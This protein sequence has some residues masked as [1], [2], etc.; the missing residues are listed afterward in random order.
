MTHILKRLEIIKSSIA[1]EELEIVEQ[2]IVKLQ[3]LNIDEE[4]RLI[5]QNLQDGAYATAENLIQ[6]YLAKFSGIVIYVDAEVQKLKLEL[7]SLESKLQNLIEQKTK[8]LSN[9]EDFNIQYNLRLG[10]LI[11]NILALKK[12]IFYKRTIKQRLQKEKYKENL[13]TFDETKETI[14]ELKNSISELEEALENIDE[15]NEEYEKL[16]KA[17]K[18]LQEELKK[19]EIELENQE[20]ELEKAKEFIEDETI[21]EEYEESK[22]NFDEYENEYNQIREN[23][24][25]VAQLSK[26]DEAELKRLYRKAARLCHPDLLP[27][28]LKAK[29]T[30]IMQQLS[31]AN[32]KK[33]LKRVKEILS[34]LENGTIF[35][36]KDY[37]IEDKIKLQEKIKEYQQKIKDT[38]D[39]IARIMADETYQTISKLDDFDGYFEELKS[40][41]ETQKEKLEE[42]ARILEEE[43]YNIRKTTQ[44]R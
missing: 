38:E 24:K 22:V 30:Q 42:E 10:G 29:A 19:L 23:Q 9:I 7:K 28:E 17:Y 14:E 35:E 21:E 33:D 25:D 6:N 11:R 3:T 40:D 39:E 12:E 43:L 34:N 13:K 16:A 32:S 2:Q 41:L 15:N 1:I 8:Y 31:D 4:V 37:E 26:D 18:E 27:D 5:I 44:K 20:E 36:N